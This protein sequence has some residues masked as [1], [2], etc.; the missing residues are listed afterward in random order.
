MTSSIASNYAQKFLQIFLRFFMIPIYINAFGVSAYGL[1]GFYITLS[2][3]LV[4]LDFGMG[5]GSIKLLAERDEKSSAEVA[6]VLRTV[7]RIYLLVSLAIGIC[8]FFCSSFIAEKWLTVD[9]QNLDAVTAIQL[10]SI[11]LLIIWPQSLYQSFLMGQQRFF[12]MNTI[13]I[14]VNT[15]FTAVMFVGIERYGYGLNFYFLAMIFWMLLQ[16]ILL[17]QFAC[18]RL[19]SK[20]LPAAKQKLKE[21]YL[22]AGGVST[23]SILSLF[24]FQGPQLI[25]SANA[26]TAELGLYN[27]SLTFPM[28]LITLMYPI[29]S[30]FFP[31]FVN[32]SNSLEA[33][34]NFVTATLLMGGFILGSAILLNFN[35]L[36][37]YDLWLGND[38]VIPNM[39]LVSQELLYATLLYG[40]VMVTNNLLLANGKTKTLSISYVL[41]VIWLVSRAI[42][43]IDNLGAMEIAIFWKETALVLLLSTTIF[44]LFTFKSLVISWVQ[45]WATLLVLS[46][47]T[48]VSIVAILEV[49]KAQTTY[50]FAASIVIALVI[51]SPLLYRIYGRLT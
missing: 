22:Y 48:Y 7:E 50:D 32:V 11:L 10:M 15:L 39:V 12:A 16:S 45:V 31:K 4:L 41:A 47:A 27:I 2:S 13:L 51:F 9:N 6:A 26:G 1:I 38:A 21:F 8:I 24:F 18:S 37:L 5:Y 17:R 28:A 25:L 35:I 30:V 44:S 19:D 34:K 20:G 3:T 43:N 23:F 40:C 42:S 29:G 14:V 49:E 33:Q 46:L 36:W